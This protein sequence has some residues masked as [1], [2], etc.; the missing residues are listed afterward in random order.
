MPAWDQSKRS[1][2]Q[3]SRSTNAASVVARTAIRSAC[4]TRRKPWAFGALLALLPI[5]LFAVDPA[6]SDRVDSALS[7]A[8]GRRADAL[9]LSSL[10]LHAYSRALESDPASRQAA[11]A[12]AAC[13]VDLYRGKEA[14]SILQSLP[15]SPQDEAERST[16]LCLALI[17]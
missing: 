8:E 3:K 5:A 14:I 15:S 16:L 2:N 11:L 17:Q 10:A 1:G 13:L 9:G 7:F 4:G 6:R 12:K